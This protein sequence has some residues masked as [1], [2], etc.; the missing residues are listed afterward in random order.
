E[1]KNN[2]IVDD[3]E[4]DCLTNWQ[5]DNRKE[6]EINDYLLNEE[7]EK[8]EFIIN[9]YNYFTKEIDNYSTNDYNYKDSKK[10]NEISYLDF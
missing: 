5:I 9:N 7:K 3:N 8:D 1:E 10:F 2:F 4:Y 6:K